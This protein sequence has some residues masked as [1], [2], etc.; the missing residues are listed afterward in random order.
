M[1]DAVRIDA[2]MTDAVMINTDAAR[3]DALPSRRCGSGPPRQ[4]GR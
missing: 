2:V 1:L 3:D 4:S